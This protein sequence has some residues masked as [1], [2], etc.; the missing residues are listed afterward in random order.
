MYLPTA[1]IRTQSRVQLTLF[2]LEG[3]VKKMWN[4]SRHFPLWKTIV[5]KYQ[6]KITSQIDE[7]MH[8]PRDDSLKFALAT[9][10]SVDHSG[11]KCS[12]TL[13]SSSREQT[14]LVLA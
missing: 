8:S 5:T 1:S 7:T 14:R 6:L 13:A 3:Y 12:P 11:K 2:Q 9:R 10:N 4:P